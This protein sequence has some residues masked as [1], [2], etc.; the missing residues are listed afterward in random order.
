MSITFQKRN[1]CIK[2]FDRCKHLPLISADEKDQGVLENQG[3]KKKRNDY[4]DKQLIIKN[5]SDKDLT[6]KKT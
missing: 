3:R 6:F 4:D 5:N 2:Y 1:G